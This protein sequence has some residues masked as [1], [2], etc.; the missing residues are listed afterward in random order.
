[1]VR[2]VAHLIY[3][4]NVIRHEGSISTCF[5]RNFMLHATT[6][7]HLNTRKI[8]IAVN[9]TA[10]NLT[11]FKTDTFKFSEISVF[12]D[13]CCYGYELLYLFLIW[14]IGHTE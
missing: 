8:K 12:L 4:R 6:H 3:S 7:P 1:M 11:S 13:K 2:C 10:D 5:K 9:T 14:C